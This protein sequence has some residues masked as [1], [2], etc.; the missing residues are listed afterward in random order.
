M[1]SKSSKRITQFKL[2]ENDLEAVRL[3]IPPSELQSMLLQIELMLSEIDLFQNDEELEDNVDPIETLQGHLIGILNPA[4]PARWH[5][6][7]SLFILNRIQELNLK[8]NS[9]LVE[10]AFKSLN[11]SINYSE[12]AEQQLRAEKLK[13][14][15]R[16]SEEGTEA[17]RKRYEPL[18]ILK[19]AAFKKYVPAIKLI[20]LRNRSAA[21]KT[22]IKYKNI[23]EIVY[24]KIEHLNHDDL[25]RKVIGRN[26]KPVQ[27]LAK[28][29]KNAVA[30]NRL[31]SPLHYRTKVRS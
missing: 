12:Q 8:N 19:E 7:L 11:L 22:L 4:E 26:N 6:V 20:R 23:A 28:I 30:E 29:F 14:K 3:S 2:L 1:K 27:S 15:Q 5:A 17:N 10:L 18:T 21:K 24:P 13:D 16:R 31:K 25:D 9:K